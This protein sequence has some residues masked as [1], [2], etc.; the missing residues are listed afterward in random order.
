MNNALRNI[1]RCSL[2]AVML[3]LSSSAMSQ[4]A[5]RQ[6]TKPITIAQTEVR[7][8]AIS[9]SEAKSAIADESRFCYQGNELISCEGALPEE[10]KTKN[11]GA[12]PP[13]PMFYINVLLGVNASRIIG[14]CPRRPSWGKPQGDLVVPANQSRIHGRTTTIRDNRSVS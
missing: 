14:R 13:P 5:N 1:V 4:E 11:E 7:E 9:Q 8:A 6:D 10:H 12:A 2:P 3:A